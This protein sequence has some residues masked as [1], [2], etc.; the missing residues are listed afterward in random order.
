MQEAAE[1][2]YKLHRRDSWP[3][4]LRDAILDI[5]SVGTPWVAYSAGEQAFMRLCA[6][7][8]GAGGSAGAV[9]LWSALGKLDHEHQVAFLD[10]L[11]EAIAP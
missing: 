7:M 9:R 1:R 11:T 5:D 3:E 10:A 2:C 8:W 4:T 6:S